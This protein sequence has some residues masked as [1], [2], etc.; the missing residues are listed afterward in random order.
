MR[1]IFKILIAITIVAVLGVTIYF[2]VAG[3]NDEVVTPVN[4]EGKD[5]ATTETTVGGSILK[6]ISDGT[7]FDFWVN[8]ETKEV[9]YFT[10]EGRVI[11]AKQGPDIEVSN[12]KVNALNFVE[13]SPSNRN[14]LAAFGNPRTP[15]WGIFDVIDGVWRPLPSDVIN[16][17]WGVSDEKLIA[18]VKSGNDLNLA[19]VDITKSPPSYKTIIR[20]FRLKDVRFTTLSDGIIIVSEFPS[21][22]YAGSLWQIDPKSSNV[23]LIIA[24]EEGLSISWSHDK[25]LAF[26]FGSNSG[27][28][29]MEN[30][31]RT[32]APTSFETLPWK[33][34]TD[35]SLIYCF[36]PQN[37]P[38]DTVLPDDY[39]MDKFFSIDDLFILGI[40]SE[41]SSKVLS[42][43]T[44]GINAIDAKN[45]QVSGD[46]IYFINRYDNNLYELSL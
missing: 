7:V 29:L 22:I 35:S 45:P 39:L 11:N 41:E 10:P 42:S 12:Q 2:L 26:V 25:N 37:T 19:E 43:N 9:F 17:A 21:A 36:V 1:P 15:Q 14:A 27:F 33:C 46:K 40:N 20:D 30:S 6:Q 44:A 28:S 18:I 4:P 5:E 38:S 13:I 31:L 34:T 8:P 23:N 32:K 3:G 16:A 24:P